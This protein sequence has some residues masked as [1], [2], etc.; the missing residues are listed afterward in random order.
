M[1]YQPVV[2]MGGLAGWS[3]LQRTRARQQ[4]A[5]NSAAVVQHDTDYFR[6]N[7]AKAKT[8]EDLVADRRLL[9]VALGAFGL[10]EDINNRAFIRQVLEGGVLKDDGLANRLSDKRYYALAKAFGYGDFSVANTQLSDFP[11]KIVENYRNQQFEVAVGEQ[12]ESL[13]LAMG[14]DR[15]LDDIIGKEMSDD[16]RWLSVM[17]SSPLRKVF[18][19]ALGLPTSFGAIDLDLQMKTLREKSE[20]ILGVSEV[21]DFADPD[22]RDKL[23]NL[24]LVRADI[25]TQGFSGSGASVALSLLQGAA[26]P[27]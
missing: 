9:S 23:R 6:A 10:Q 15:L 1:T 12:D 24:F 3:F 21:S 7:V 14:V 22:L 27:G 25:A 19:G 4:E 26:S 20:K 13:R 8:A 18:E 17:G 16:G 11:D 5:F 2:P